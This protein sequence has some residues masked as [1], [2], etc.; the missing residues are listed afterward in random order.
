MTGYSK[1]AG[2]F[3]SAMLV[4]GAANAAPRLSPELQQQAV[5]MRLVTCLAQAAH[6]HDDGI[7]DP[8]RIA[9]RI[10]PLC[11]ADF[12]RE[13]AVY[14]AN[15]AASDQAQYRAIMDDNRTTLAA[16]V[17][18]HERAAANRVAQSY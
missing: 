16:E 15:L 5:A 1:I 6:R 17:V 9:A 2:V 4:A 11:D 7:S 10:A 3:V 18:E 14:G 12:S 8:Y 13:E